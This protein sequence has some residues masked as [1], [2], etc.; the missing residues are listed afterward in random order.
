MMRLWSVISA[1]T[2]ATEA[3]LESQTPFPPVNALDVAFRRM[4]WHPFEFNLACLHCS[5]TRKLT[6]NKLKQVHGKTYTKSGNVHQSVRLPTIWIFSFAKRFFLRPTKALTKLCECPEAPRHRRSNVMTLH[7]R[8][9]DV[10][11]IFC[12]HWVT[13]LVLHDIL[14][15]QYTSLKRQADRN[16]TSIFAR[17]CN[18]TRK[19][20]SNI[21]YTFK[22]NFA[23]WNTI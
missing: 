10:V 23:N 17:S 18:M 7:G 13:V 19:C 8:W 16:L 1:G 2:P 11:S 22:K 21:S 4:F 5:F 3:Q 15:L 20:V 14:Q 6:W 12:V 9:F